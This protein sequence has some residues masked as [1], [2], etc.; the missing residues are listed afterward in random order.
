MDVKQ[1][2]IRVLAD[3]PDG[4]RVPEIHRLVAESSGSSLQAEH[5]R[6]MLS[7]STDPIVY[8]PRVANALAGLLREKLVSPM[9]GGRIRLT[10]QGQSASAKETREVHNT[11]QRYKSAT[12]LKQRSPKSGGKAKHAVLAGHR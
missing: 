5:I 7:E 8:S 6:P 4:L 11:K 9:G 10:D 2:L 1:T 3:H 12:P